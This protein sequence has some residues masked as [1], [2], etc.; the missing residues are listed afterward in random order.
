MH[1]YLV[2]LSRPISGKRGG[3]AITLAARQ[4]AGRSLGDSVVGFVR[5]MKYLD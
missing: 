5:Q 4:A 1:S 2:T 3:P